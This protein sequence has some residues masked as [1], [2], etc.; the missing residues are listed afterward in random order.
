MYTVSFAIN[1]GKTTAPVEMNWNVYMY[2]Y[3]LV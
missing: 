1:K 2:K 3:S